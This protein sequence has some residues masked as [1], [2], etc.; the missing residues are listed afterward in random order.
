MTFGLI[1][2][3]FEVPR[4][5]EHRDGYVQNTEFGVKLIQLLLLLMKSQ[6]KFRMFNAMTVQ[7]QQAIIIFYIVSTANMH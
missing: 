3:K 1:L 6:E 2:L 7:L 4:H 5:Q